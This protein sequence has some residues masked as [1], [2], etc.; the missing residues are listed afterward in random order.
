MTMASRHAT[1]HLCC[2]QRVF[3]FF[4]SYFRRPFSIW[5]WNPCFLGFVVLEKG[6]VA[7]SLFWKLF[8][9]FRFVVL[10]NVG[11]GAFFL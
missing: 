4:F 11:S 2:A 9:L 7:G 5:A 1:H 10:E 3:F 8:L 6:F